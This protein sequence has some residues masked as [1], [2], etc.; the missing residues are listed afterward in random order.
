MVALTA[1]NRRLDKTG[2]PSILHPLRIAA[3]FPDNEPWAV[4]ALLHGVVEDTLDTYHQ[5]TLPDIEAQFGENIAT[6]VGALTQHRH[7]MLYRS[8]DP[9]SE[10]KIATEREA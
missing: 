3:R 10:W 9:G 5:I 7:G 6:Q 1:Y 2:L 4:I 8:I